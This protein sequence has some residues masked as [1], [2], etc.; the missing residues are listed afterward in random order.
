MREPE[1]EIHA[2]PSFAF[3][4][5]VRSR[6]NVRNDGTFMGREVGER[7]VDKGEIG[8]VRDI[9]TFLQR[10]YIYAVEFVT[11]GLVVGMRA[12]E[13]EPVMD[14]GQGES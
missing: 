12:R 6:R 13:L 14:A 5:K 4:Q 9:G 2:D 7:L 1:I 8:Y 10:Y 11:S 3:G